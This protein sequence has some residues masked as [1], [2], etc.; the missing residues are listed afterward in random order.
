MNDAPSAPCPAGGTPVVVPQVEPSERW[1]A[2]FR[3]G[4]AHWLLT[5]SQSLLPVPGG[6]RPKKC[7]TLLFREHQQDGSFSSP[8]SLLGCESNATHNTA[9]ACL[10]PRGGVGPTI[11]AFGNALGFGGLLRLT[12]ERWPAPGAPAL[13]SAPSPIVSSDPL[14]SGCREDRPWLKNQ[15][16]FDGKLS[17]VLR[18][19]GR[20]LLFARANTGQAHPDTRTHVLGGAGGRHVQLATSED[21]AGE[22]FSRFELLR[23]EGYQMHPHNNIYWFSATPHRDRLLGFFPGV[24]NQVSGVWMTH[25][26]GDDALAW[27]A[28]ELL[29]SSKHKLGVGPY[30]L[31]MDGGRTSDHPVEA[32]LEARRMEEGR[33]VVPPLATGASRKAAPTILVH[34]NVSMA[35]GDAKGLKGSFEKSKAGLP[36]LHGREIS[37][38]RFCRHKL[39]AQLLRW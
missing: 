9:L 3:C 7:W 19:R 6:R 17:V 35:G 23:F 27:S 28:P 10:P 12:M 15:C 32:S 38:S 16:E 14:V 26:V 29:M 24:I 1:A 11:V 31:A 33:H 34:H 2:V 36:A 18:W 25:T 39:P 30:V 21:G 4:R 37:P 22:R 8:A 5:R 13:W 20:L